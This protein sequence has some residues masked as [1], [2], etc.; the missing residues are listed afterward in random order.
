MLRSGYARVADGQ[1]SKRAEFKRKQ[2]EAKQ[3]GY[4]LWN[5]NA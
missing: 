5:T 4:G 3:G 2:Q 1:F